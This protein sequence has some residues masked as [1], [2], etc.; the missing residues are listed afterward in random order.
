MHCSISVPADNNIIYVNILY[1]S[2]S[3]F[4]FFLVKIFDMHAILLI[5]KRGLWLVLA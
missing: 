1:L 3:S 4:N 5:I 2:H